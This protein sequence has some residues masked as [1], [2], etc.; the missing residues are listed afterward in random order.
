MKAKEAMSIREQVANWRKEAKDLH[1]S[2]VGT[3]AESLILEAC[4]GKLETLLH[5]LVQED[6]ADLERFDG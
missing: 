1:E 2:G 6:I 5:R 3:P 4:A